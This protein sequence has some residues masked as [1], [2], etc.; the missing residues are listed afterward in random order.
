MS[1]PFEIRFARPALV[2]SCIGRCATNA[3][4][5]HALH[6]CLRCCPRV[7]GDAA[8]V[9]HLLAVLRRCGAG[10]RHFMKKALTMFSN[11][12][13]VPVR[14]P[15][16]A[17]LCTVAAA[18]LWSLLGLCALAGAAPETTAAE[19]T[20]PTIVHL[21]D[22]VG[23]D[24]PATV[25]DG[26]V[27][28]AAE[29][30]EQR[31]FVAQAITLLGQL[32]ARPAQ[33]ALI[34][35]ARQLH[36]LVAA[37]AAGPEVAAAADGLRWDVVRAYAIAV[38]PR[39]APDMAAA[40]R[41][42]AAQCASCHG[43]RGHG[44]G[45]AAKGMDP[46][47]ANFH[48]GQRMRVR[49]V[50]GLYNTLTL[51]VAGTPMRAFKELSD[52]DR[53]ALALLVS[54]LRAP[55]EQLQ[56]GETAWRQGQGQRAITSLKDLVSRTPAEVSAEQGAKGEA[57][58]AYLSSHPDALQARAA[59]PLEL[60]RAKLGHS[61]QRYRAGD[62]EDA[63]QL[64]VGAY[65]E[66]FELVERSLDNVDTVLR[67]EIEREMMALRSA[68]AESQ[69][70]DAVAARISHIDSLLERAQDKLASAGLSPGTAFASSLLIL[71]REGLEAILVLAAIVAFVRKTGRRDAL[72]YVHLGWIAALA[73]G[74]LTWWVA[75]T[76]I[77]IS[78][79]NRE[80]TEGVTALIAS[81]M[82]LYVGYW[83]HSK[84]YANAW[85][86]FIR[87]QVNAAL[88]RGTLWAMAAISFLAVYRELFEIVLF[89]QSLWAQ[90]GAAGQAGVLAGIGVAALL[91]ALL[92]WV[93]LRYS[94]RLPLGQFFSAT[95]GLLALL[96]VVFA[97]NGVAALQEGGVIAA[98]PIR[99]ISVPLLGLHPTLQG[100][101]AQAVVLG[102]VLLGMLLAARQHH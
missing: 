54:T 35:R 66:G 101:T 42:Y 47:P 49:S 37:R 73:L 87:D 4:D 65:L 16:R 86:H 83:L 39:R 24:Y 2:P 38:A 80:L 29:Y 5:A 12:H 102:L 30:D 97:G 41:I 71:L 13:L 63:R 3:S 48:D 99:F 77:S 55:A 59:A 25:H 17:A 100:V 98:D 27:V 40:T 70:A 58:L 60:T 9:V 23:V 36:A 34:E 52:D 64:A 72:A 68:I 15:I 79:A 33:P 93:I 44:D 56:T 1:P 7:L 89:Y 81:A 85:Q 14:A 8:P 90:A 78:G 20:G 45:P 94:V 51:G 50:Y 19:D 67:V 92:A 53:W 95:S 43:Q 46:A 61:L 21:L 31:E 62:R 22:Y 32:P 6:C 74:A 57:L 96:S 82:L 11:H 10:A 28:D 26:K 69:P 88:G 75:S 91:L 76:M 84:S 18:L